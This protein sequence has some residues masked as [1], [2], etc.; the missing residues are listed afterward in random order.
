MVLVGAYSFREENHTVFLAT[1]QGGFNPG[2]VQFGTELISGSV[3][4]T[5]YSTSP[6]VHAQLTWTTISP[7]VFVVAVKL[8]SS[9]G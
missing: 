1:K 2:V 5:M 8:K 4:V 9:T 7:S 3:T 6:G